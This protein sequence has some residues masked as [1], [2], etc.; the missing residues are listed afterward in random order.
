MMLMLIITMMSTMSGTDGSD[1][2][3]RYPT[4]MDDG[5]EDDGDD[6][7]TDDDDDVDDE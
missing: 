4:I 1:D 2:R 7:D 5:D 3:L 6:V